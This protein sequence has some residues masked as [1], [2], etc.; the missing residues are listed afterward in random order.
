MTP[1]V[2]SLVRAARSPRSAW[3]RSGWRPQIQLA[4]VPADRV[5]RGQRGS[6][7]RQQPGGEVDHRTGHPEAGDQFLQHGLGMAEVV[8]RSSQERVAHGVVA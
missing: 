7:A 4:A 6:D 3:P 5:R 1:M 8:Q 2:P